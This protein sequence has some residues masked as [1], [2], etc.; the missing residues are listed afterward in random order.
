MRYSLFAAAALAAATMVTPAS[1]IGI[2][3]NY[4]TMPG[5]GLPDCMGRA[6]SALQSAGVRLLPPTSEA[7]WAENGDGTQIF[8]VYCLFRN[9]LAVVIGAG[10]SSRDVDPTVSTIVRGLTGGGGGPVV[11][12]RNPLTGG[13]GGGNIK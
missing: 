4:V 10:P 3:M 2:S 8:T 6:S 7:Q 9:G 12:P 13:G 11:P 1:A 5:V